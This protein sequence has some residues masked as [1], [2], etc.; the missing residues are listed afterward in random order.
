MSEIVIAYEHG[1]ILIFDSRE[2][3]EKYL[4]PI[5]VKNDEYI[6]YNGD[7]KRLIANVVRDSNG[8]DRTVIFE[9]RVDNSAQDELREILTRLLTLSGFDLD[10]LKNMTLSELVSVSLKFKIT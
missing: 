8:I 4:E 2:R 1:D 7:G 10:S 6:L 9:D 5:D 3:A